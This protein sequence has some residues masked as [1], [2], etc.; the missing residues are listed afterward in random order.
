MANSLLD[1]YLGDGP[2]KKV[3]TKPE[4]LTGGLTDMYLSPSGNIA[5]PTVEPVIKRSTVNE[6]LAGFK[7]GLEDVINT[8]GEAIGLAD[9]AATGNATRN[10]AFKERVAKENRDYEANY[11]ESTPAEI[12]RVGGGVLATAPLIPSKIPQGIN[13]ATRALPKILPTGESIAAPL[14][15]RLGAAVGTGAVGG[16]TYSLWTSAGSKEPLSETIPEGIITGAIAGP[17]VYGAGKLGANV[18]PQTWKSVNTSILANN[19]KLP[20]S[21][22]ENIVGRLEDAGLTPIDAQKALNKMGPKAT[23]MDLDEALSS[24][25]SGLASFGGKATSIIKGRMA[26]RAAT[27]NDDT[28]KNVQKTFGPKPDMFIER[29]TVK[30]PEAD[31]IVKE[32]QR[33]TKADYDAAHNSKDFLDVNPILNDITTKLNTAVGPKAQ[34]LEL[35]RGYLYKADGSIK[36]DVAS[37]HEVRQ[38]IDDVIDGKNPTT[39]YGKNALS[40]INNVRDKVDDLLKTNNEMKSADTKFAKKMEVKNGL[41]LGVDAIQKGTSKEQFERIYDNADP[42]VKDTI[43]KGMLW[44][45]YESLERS[46]QGEASQAQRLFGKKDI[47]RSNFKYAFGTNAENL[48]DEIEKS[49]AFKS[50]EHLVMRGAQTAERQA[51]QERYTKQGSGNILSEAVKGAA[52]DVATGSPALAASIMGGRRAVGNTV[53]KISENKLGRLVEGSAD[54]LSQSGPEIQNTLQALDSVKRVNDSLKSFRTKTLKL[55]AT[56]SSPIGE[57]AYSKYKQAK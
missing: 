9:E 17:V 31:K 44:A 4:A 50:T 13:I 1:L 29:G 7:K 5:I 24:E 6:G 43:R 55:P 42:D 22:I 39:S 57:E 52:L 54:I 33:L 53:V 32:A 36:N 8:G 38:A 3:E 51:I 18:I 56:L 15:N 45:T 14:I 28:I 46:G 35:I 21:A 11:G 2:T 20:A 49:T 10:D 47:N 37:L 12:G 16:G 25:G 19:A 26:N 40:A 30:G 41:K 23:L 48:L 34:A 27:A